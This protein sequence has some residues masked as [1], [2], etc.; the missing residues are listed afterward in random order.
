MPGFTVDGTPKSWPKQ[1]DDVMIA[2]KEV[3]G[4][5]LGGEPLKVSPTD[6]STRG[7]HPRV[8]TSF[9]AKIN[10]DFLC[11][12]TSRI[13]VTST[14]FSLPDTFCNKHKMAIYR[15]SRDK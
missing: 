8:Q 9:R 12:R 2:G 14:P 7:D 6:I 4:Q 13:L 3:K 15:Q 11:Y 1:V 5:S 10:L